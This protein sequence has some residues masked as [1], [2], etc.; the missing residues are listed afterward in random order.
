MS[1]P[2]SSVQ[3]FTGVVMLVNTWVPVHVNGN[4]K[5]FIGNPSLDIK[6]AQVVA[7]TF[8][9]QNQ[10]QFVPE[11]LN[12]DRPLITIWKHDSKWYPAECHPRKLTLLQKFCDLDLGGTQEEAAHWADI[13]AISKNADFLPIIGISVDQAEKKA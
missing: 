11:P 9:E 7:K 4:K 10:I 5:K 8:A 6:I 13:I 1:S 3:N 2:S 12:A